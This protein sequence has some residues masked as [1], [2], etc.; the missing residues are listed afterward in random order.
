[1]LNLQFHLQGTAPLILHNIEAADPLNEWSKQLSKISSKK[2]KTEEDHAEMERIQWFSGLYT[3]PFIKGPVMPTKC[4]RKAF[5][6]G[7]RARKLG[8]HIERGLKF[9]DMAVSIIHDG[10]NDFDE[11]F[12]NNYY[13]S[14]ESV[15]V[16]NSRIIRVRPKFPKWQIIADASL[17]T[18]ILDLDELQSVIEYTGRIEG[19]AD[20][21]IN[22]FGR[23]EA[24]INVLTTV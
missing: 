10:P 16:N 11:L 5:I 3:D 4:L 15:K 21:R 17:D 13:H 8:R 7:G 2:K 14:R 22:G 9:H 12:K 23:F 20:N 18:D 19:L 24:K 1:M 6:V